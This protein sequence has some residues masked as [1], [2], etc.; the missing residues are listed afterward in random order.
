[1]NQ[2]NQRTFWRNYALSKS[3]TLLSRL[4]SARACFWPGLIS[5]PV[6][7]RLQ[8]SYMRFPHEGVALPPFHPAR[9][10]LATPMR[11]DGSESHCGAR[12]PVLCLIRALH[13][14]VCKLGKSL[15]L[16]RSCPS[17]RADRQHV[18]IPPPDLGRGRR[19]AGGSPHATRQRPSRA[20]PLPEPERPQGEK[21]RLGGAPQRG[22]A[23][24]RSTQTWI[25]RSLRKR[26]MR[27]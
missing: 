6:S 12:S 1:M 15:S 24:T 2:R 5:E 3:R 25:G 17:G 21:A 10:G 23:K 16:S 27:P 13:P 14:C 9:S 20:A 26:V 4:N 11:Y 19:A 18:L 8:T 22:E 7:R